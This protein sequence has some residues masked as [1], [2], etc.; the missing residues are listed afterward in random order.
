MLYTIISPAS[1]NLN[2]NTNRYSI[3]ALVNPANPLTSVQRSETKMDTIAYTKGL[4][5]SPG[6]NNCFLNSAVQVCPS[7]FISTSLS[8]YISIPL[9]PS[10]SHFIQTL[11]TTISLT[12]PLSLYQYTSSFIHISL[13]V[14]SYLSFSPISILPL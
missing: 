11:S 6:E 9:S 5:N 4:Q 14:S 7:T 1:P 12:S 10:L 13:P 2:S 3:D 8:I